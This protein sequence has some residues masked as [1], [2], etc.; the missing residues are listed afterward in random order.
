MFWKDK[1]KSTISEDIENPGKLIV[2]EKRNKKWH[3]VISKFVLFTILIQQ[4]SYTDG[5]AFDLPSKSA[6]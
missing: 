4:T 5:T 6:L 3:Q 2:F 1:L